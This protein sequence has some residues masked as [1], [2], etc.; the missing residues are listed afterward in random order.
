GEPARVLAA[1]YEALDLALDPATVGGAADHTAEAT[2]EALARALLAVLGA[3]GAVADG[4]GEA[5]L[6]R[7]AGL[8][9]EFA[10]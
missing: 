7:A 9:G 4:P 5:V 10:A 2:H 8:V 1:V 6:E 3:S